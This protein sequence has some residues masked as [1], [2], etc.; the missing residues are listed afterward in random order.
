MGLD[1]GII[2][3]LSKM[4]DLKSTIGFHI[5]FVD[6]ASKLLAFILH[7]IFVDNSWKILG[8][9]HNEMVKRNLWTFLGNQ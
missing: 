5:Y 7:G 6:Y 9:R 8:P 4:N 3:I 1:E 2:D